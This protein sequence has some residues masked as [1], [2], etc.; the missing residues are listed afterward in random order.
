MWCTVVY[1]WYQKYCSLCKYIQYRQRQ[2]K[3][4]K[5]FIKQIQLSNYSIMQKSLLAVF[6][7]DFTFFLVSSFHFLGEL[8]I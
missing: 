3:N 7:H 6:A 1:I 5:L 8:D 4:S 2:A